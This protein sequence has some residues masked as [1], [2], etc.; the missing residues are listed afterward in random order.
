MK[1]IG[2]AYVEYM[3]DITEYFEKES[4]K[5]FGRP[6]KHTLLI[7]ANALNGDYLDE[8]LDMYQQKGYLFIS[9]EEALAD[10]AYN[11]TDNYVGKR[12]ISWLHRWAL[13]KQVENYSIEEEPTCPEFI[14]TIA[15]IKD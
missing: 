15:G 3:K 11:S 9:L 13:T 10:K 4:S 1:K 8:L 6:I 12:G 2:I 5:L 7:H 14:E